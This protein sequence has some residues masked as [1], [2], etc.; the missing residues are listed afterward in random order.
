MLRRSNR[1]PVGHGGELLFDGLYDLIGR[2]PEAWREALRDRETFAINLDSNGLH[3]AGTVDA[4]PDGCDQHLLVYSGF[5]AKY[6]VRANLRHLLLSLAQGKP[7]TTRVLSFERGGPVEQVLEPIAREEAETI[8]HQWIALFC[9][10]MTTPLPFFEKASWA[11]RERGID[12]ARKAFA[13]D[14][15]PDGVFDDRDDPAIRRCYGVEA[16]DDPQFVAAF[17]RCAGILLGAF[18][19][20]EAQI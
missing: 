4:A 12:A 16:F 3:I 11:W 19:W 7:V 9:E 2:I 1:L 18:E 8:L 10:G 15:K 14:Y 5:K 13:L 17:E 20:K 6:A